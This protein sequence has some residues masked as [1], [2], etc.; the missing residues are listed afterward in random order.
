M[1]VGPGFIPVCPSLHAPWPGPH[2]PHGAAWLPWSQ[3][4][5]APRSTYG[6]ERGVRRGRRHSEPRPLS[7]DQRQRV[8]VGVGMSEWSLTW[9]FG[10][11][12]LP[13]WCEGWSSAQTLSPGERK[14][15]GKW[16]EGRTGGNRR[17]R[18]WESPHTWTATP[19]LFPSSIRGICSCNQVVTWEEGI[20]S[21]MS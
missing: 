9:R 3:H 6:S 2:L 17:T 14:H 21:N 18:E 8:P 19:K 20:V 12:S 4:R 10:C 16:K 5:H 13:A 7:P 11:G 15:W 1:R